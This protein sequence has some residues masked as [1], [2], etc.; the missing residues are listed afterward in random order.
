[1]AKDTEVYKDAVLV[2]PP[3]TARPS[4][5]S[6]HNRT[7]V[8]A[9]VSRE[10][11][12]YILL[13][14]RTLS[15]QPMLTSGRSSDGVAVYDVCRWTPPPRMS[16]IGQTG[17][18]LR[19][20]ACGEHVVPFLPLDPTSSASSS[21]GVKRPTSPS[22]SRGVKRSRSCSTEPTSS[23]IGVCHVFDLSEPDL[24]EPLVQAYIGPAA[25]DVPPARS[26]SPVFRRGA[27]TAA[28][29]PEELRK[30]AARYMR[31]LT[32]LRGSRCLPRKLL[33][34]TNS[35]FYAAYTDTALNH[36][37]FILSQPKGFLSLRVFGA[38][39]DRSVR[40]L[41]SL[42]PVMCPERRMQCWADLP[43]EQLHA[44]VMQ[45][46]VLDSC[47]APPPPL[48]FVDGYVLEMKDAYQARPFSLMR[49]CCIYS[50][51]D[52][53]LP[54]L[55]L[56]CSL[57]NFAHQTRC[58]AAYAEDYEPL[59]LLELVS[60]VRDFWQYARYSAECAMREG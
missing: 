51:P 37:R 40:A 41:H 20:Q 58:S 44:L 52:A 15:L 23:Q 13:C 19:S 56:P 34:Y 42:H 12:Q 35:P 29:S 4:R 50:N 16:A 33:D 49:Y 48:E 25:S 24:A 27:S 5:E 1:M 53:L 11:A 43:E 46:S 55:R 2:L 45:A 54:P 10:A 18:C 3:R 47:V 36:V 60:L 28:M 57:L 22:S 59:T 14:D 9:I 39:P 31:G 7:G 17:A 30:H 6:L 21:P 32:V 38:A 8:A 26:G